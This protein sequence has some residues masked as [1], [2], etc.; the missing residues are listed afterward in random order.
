MNISELFYL[1][2]SV[3]V[4]VTPLMSPRTAKYV[5]ALMREGDN[6][7]YFK[8]LGEVREEEAQ[9][10]RVPVSFTSGAPVAG[11]IGNSISKSDYGTWPNSTLV[12]RVAPIPRAIWRP[13]HEP[14]RKTAKARLARRLDK[15][16][17]A[18]DDFQASRARDA[19]YGYLEA[20]FAIVEHYKVRRRT[21]KLLRHAFK[22][23]NLPFDK[24]ADPF[25]AAIRCTCD[26]Q[27]DS[28]TISRWARALR[29]AAHCKA[30]R[31]RLKKFMKE[32]GGVNACA[33]RYA[34]FKRRRNRRTR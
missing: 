30:P 2:N 14:V 29:Y 32:A 31:T 7:D 4:R 20:V 24:N 34:N 12:S 9:A 10:K 23:A 19:V 3:P 26:D 21:K 27:V 16:A 5:E 6:F 15:V 28:K 8:W 11:E 22:F 33:D 17:D 25:T 13:S 18:W 1:G